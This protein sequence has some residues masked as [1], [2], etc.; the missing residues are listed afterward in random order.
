MILPTNKENPVTTNATGK[1]SVSVKNNSGN[2]VSSATVVL[3]NDE[4]EFSG[5]TGSAGGC[6]INN[7]PVGTYTVETTADDYEDGLDN[8]TV[9][10]GNNNLNITLNMKH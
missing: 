7:V 9:V 8:I 2:G 1:V 3:S 5:T 6:T 4:L 10:E